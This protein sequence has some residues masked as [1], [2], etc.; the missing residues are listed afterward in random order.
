MGA[1]KRAVAVFRNSGNC[2]V[3]PRSAAL[4]RSSVTVNKHAR[5]RNPFQRE[6]QAEGAVA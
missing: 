2:L 3:V 4:T 5:T 6:L 1:E